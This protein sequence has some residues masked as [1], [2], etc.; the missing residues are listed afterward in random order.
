MINYFPKFTFIGMTFNLGLSH[1]KRVVHFLGDESR[2]LVWF[3]PMVKITQIKLS[4]GCR[5]YQWGKSY[6]AW[7]VCQTQKILKIKLKIKMKMIQCIQIHQIISL[8]SFLLCVCFWKLLLLLSIVLLHI[9]LFCIIF[10]FVN[11][12]YNDVVLCKL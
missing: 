3:S 4:W 1:T 7:R 12:Y 10:A 8:P 5:I 11:L 2:L 6:P 9:D